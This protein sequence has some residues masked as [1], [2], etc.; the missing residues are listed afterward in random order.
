[1][2]HALTVHVSQSVS[3]L[4]GDVERLVVRQNR[5]AHH[6]AQRQALDIFHRDIDAAFFDRCQYVNNAWMTQAAADFF[7]ALK[8][9]VK[10][11]VAFELQVGDFDYNGGVVER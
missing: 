3:E 6:R 2:Y 8:T 9:S 11:D 7:L 1:M 10:D 4:S 5:I